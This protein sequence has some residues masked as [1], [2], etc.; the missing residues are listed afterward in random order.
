MDSKK[1]KL[2][3][4]KIVSVKNDID[5]EK[6][7]VKELG[8]KSIA[9]IKSL[10]LEDQTVYLS[11]KERSIERLL[12]LDHLHGSPF[13]MKLELTSSDGEEKRIIYLAKHHFTQDE[14]YSWVAPIASVR[15]DKPGPVE[16][17]LPGGKLERTILSHKEQYMIVQGKIVFFAQESIDIPRELIYQEHFSSKK[18]GFILPEIVA[19][20]EKA[21]D[22][23]IRAHHAGP[24][25]ISGPAGSGKTTLALHRVAYLVQAPD[26]SHLY[27]ENSIIVF[28]Q[29]NGTKEYF[30]HLLPDLGIHKVH[31]TTFFEWATA[32][33]GITGA[34]HIDRRGI[35]EDDKDMKE[36]ERLE[37]LGAQRIP[38]W[39]ESKKFLAKHKDSGL[40]R[41]DLTLALI[42]YHKQHDGF[43]I[44]KSYMTTDRVGKFIHKT[45]KI[46]PSYSLIIIDEFQNYMPEQLK[47]MNLCIDEKT[48]STIYVG[49]MAQQV[50]PGTIRSWDSIGYKTVEEREVRLHKVYRNTREIL[51]Y[52]RGLGYHIEIPEGIKSGKPVSE[53][54]ITY[55]KKI[56][57]YVR[58]DWIQH[59]ALSVS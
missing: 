56:I 21:Q 1:L 47:L 25:I 3:N 57:E 32:L 7:R 59:K 54:I 43:E 4:E 44:K 17:L 51:E 38:S 18:D 19:V 58:K 6:I 52:V 55:E 31:I 16:Y 46:I 10:S 45:R 39:H 5:A 9:E 33:L 30:S 40:Y 37:I 34:T 24:F 20:M 36:F 48:K 42:S 2:L 27:P 13:F 29:D 15:F 12:E 35:D 11:T 53:K 23:V 8:N 50:L 22:V 28:V 26:T 14:I 49:D 41:I